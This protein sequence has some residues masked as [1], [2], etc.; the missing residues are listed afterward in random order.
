MFVSS[1]PFTSA[2]SSDFQIRYVVPSTSVNVRG[3]IDPR[4]SS[5]QTNGCGSA[6]NGPSGDGP[7]AMPMHWSAGSV[8]TTIEVKYKT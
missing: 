6:V 5:W 1:V 8:P 2:L 7:D 3:S 4:W